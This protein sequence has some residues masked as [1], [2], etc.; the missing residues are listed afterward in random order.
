MYKRKPRLPIELTNLP[1]NDSSD[2]DSLCDVTAPQLENH[3][4]LMME[5]TDNKVKEN[6]KKAQQKQKKQFDAKHRKPE[7]KV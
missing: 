5:W 3:M 4:Q 6:I 2:N 1:Q 7:F